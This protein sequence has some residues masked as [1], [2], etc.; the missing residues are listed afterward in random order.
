M[1]AF[2]FALIGMMPSVRVML[3]GLSDIPLGSPNPR[4]Y[5]QAHLNA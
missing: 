3:D 4:F 5:P 1:P 2:Y